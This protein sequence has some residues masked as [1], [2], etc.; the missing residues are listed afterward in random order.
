MKDLF[1]KVEING[2]E[3][4]NRLVRS[5]TWEGM[6]DDDGRPSEKL[7]SYYR[8]LARG[9]VGLVVS[10]YAY[11]QPEG[12]Q[13]PGKMG[14]YTDAFIP[15]LKGLAKAVHEEGGALCVQLVHAGGQT[16][17]KA[18]GRTPLAPSAIEAAQYQGVTPVEMTAKDMADTVDAFA[19]AARRC[20]EAGADAVQLHAA[21]G[22]LICQFL[23]PLTNHRTDE[24]GGSIENRGR[25]MREVCDSVRKAVGPDYPVLVK[26][27]GSDNVEGGLSAEDALEAARMLDEAGVDAIEVSGGTPGSGDLGPV[28]AKIN[29]P[30]R[31]AYNLALA[32]G[33]K[34]HVRCPV[35]SVGGYRSIEK[36]RE[37]LE[38]IDMVALSRPLIRE[39]G[40]PLR[41]AGPDTSPARC[42]SCNKCFLPGIKEGGI[43]CVVE[44]KEREKAGRKE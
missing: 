15:E 2:M 41:W 20:R 5:A 27:N 8:E 42:I 11:V 38:G 14:V 13:M 7:A 23:S 30:E 26:L 37:A 39:P 33:I 19:Q 12:K 16:T 43:Y 3:V 44:K 6:C 32:L 34:A 21:H 28:R 24:Y 29:R 36:V 4:R 9:G 22:Y 40:L 17:Q 10:G 25:F 35:I 18:I 31:E 1:D